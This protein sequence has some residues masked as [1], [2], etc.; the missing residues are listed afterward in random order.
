[1][2]DRAGFVEKWESTSGVGL[3]FEYFCPDRDDP[4]EMLRQMRAPAI[5]GCFLRMCREVADLCEGAAKLSLNSALESGFLLLRDIFTRLAA[6]AA[7][8][9]LDEPKR[10]AMAG[11]LGF[12]CRAWVVLSDALVRGA[13]DLQ[14]ADDWVQ[15]IHRRA[16]GVS[17]IPID[18]TA[19]FSGEAPEIR[20][21]LQTYW[22]A[23]A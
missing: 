4:T 16:E 7:S 12:S 13:P 6:C 2:F 18:S 14:L 11:I 21:A 9:T 22:N 3:L 20:G 15:F 1:M 5:H 19:K 10:E 8:S 23:L 17:P